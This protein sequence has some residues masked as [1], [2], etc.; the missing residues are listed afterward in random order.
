[1]ASLIH[2]FRR[3]AKRS[4]AGE[5]GRRSRGTREIA[6]GLGAYAAYLAVRRV[7]WTEAGR[8]RADRNAGRLIAFER[9]LGMFFEPRLQAIA[10]RAPRLVDVLNAG[11]AAGNVAL[12]VGWLIRLY[13]R[14]DSGFGTERRAAVIAFVAALPVFLAFPTA[15]PRTQEGFVDTLA[16]RG[17]DL[18]HPFLVRLYNPIAAMPSHHVAFASVTGEGLAARG[19]GPWVRAGWRGYAPLVAVVVVATGNHFVVDVAAGAALGGLARR[20]AR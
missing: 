15:P 20:L 10:L 13:A 12:S 8:A 18:G 14:G 2:E 9:R 17:I 6:I 7:V 11:Y 3:A 16:D 5:L 4:G 1:M 19:G